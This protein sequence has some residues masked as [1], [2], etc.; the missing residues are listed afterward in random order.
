MNSLNY[1]CEDWSVVSKDSVTWSADIK[2]VLE[3]PE[4]QILRD[5]FIVE[6]NV[7]CNVTDMS[8]LSQLTGAEVA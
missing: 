6:T 8:L 2:V 5:V 1:P 7:A 3:H 4:R